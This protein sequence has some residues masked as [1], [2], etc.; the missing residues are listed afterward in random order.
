V[1]RAALL[2][3][4]VFAAGAVYE[5]GCA[6]W[7]A[8]VGAGRKLPAVVWSGV[9]CVVTLTGVEALLPGRPFAAAYVVG[10][11]AGTWLSMLRRPATMDAIAELSDEALDDEVRRLGGDPRKLERAAA[12]AIRKR[13]EP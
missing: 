11:M 3:T 1:S 8:H 5:F 9:N 4:A 13:G 12:E 7:V 10:F 2:L 6:R